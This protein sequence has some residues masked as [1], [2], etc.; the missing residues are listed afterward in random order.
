NNIKAYD[1]T[2]S[3]LRD[4]G[5]VGTS[6]L[7]QNL[8]KGKGWMIYMAEGSQF[9]DLN[10]AIWN[11]D[12]NLP[13][14]YTDTA[15]PLEDGWNLVA[16]PYACT[17]NWDVSTPAWTKTNIDDAIYVFDAELQVYSSYVNGVGNNG[18]SG[19]IA[20]FQAFWTKANAVDPELVITEQAKNPIQ[21]D[22]KDAP[23]I[24]LRL[25][26]GSG[27]HLDET[28]FYWSNEATPGFDSELEAE[29]FYLGESTTIASS[30]E[31]GMMLSIQALSESADEITI[32]LEVAIYNSRPWN[33]AAEGWDQIHNGRCMYM[34]DAE[35]NINYPLTNGEFASIELEE[36]IYTERFSLRGTSSFLSEK[37]NPSCFGSDDG[38]ISVA[39][40]NATQIEWFNSNDELVLASEMNESTLNNLS[41]GI[42]HVEVT[43]TGVCPSL[44]MNVSLV[45]PS[46]L[47]AQ[48]EIVLPSCPSASDGAIMMENSGGTSPYQFYWSTEHQDASI[49]NLEVGTYEMTVVDANGCLLNQI[50]ELPAQNNP[51]VHF[52]TDPIFN[53]E[54]GIAVVHFENNSSGVDNFIW[55][56]DDGNLSTEEDLTHIYNEAGTYNVTLT[57]TAGECT[58]TWEQEITIQFPLD[59]N[60]ELQ[61]HTSVSWSEF[62]LNINQGAIQQP[63]IVNVYNVLGQKL[64]ETKSSDQQIFLKI[65]PYIQHVLIEIQTVDGSGRITYNLAK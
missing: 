39:L 47:S 57:G 44:S 58:E 55:S 9:I 5:F 31:N 11:G 59:I 24:P 26:I 12:Q 48:N 8:Q 40:E 34:H 45:E 53:L 10:G 65:P 7:D 38:S 64:A 15:N 30:T 3:G 51:Q 25:T 46:P 62:G 14:T 19:N 6:G 28:T 23:S 29:K 16:N 32:P 4:E 21:V 18:G 2:Q 52:S 42:Y 49:F 27:N 20:P 41:P 13:V 54:G 36:G 50:F 43:S 33:F 60:N 35:T 61:E 17:I 63:L 56:L 37:A 1:E 22:F